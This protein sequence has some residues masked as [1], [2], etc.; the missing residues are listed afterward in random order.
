V[1]NVLPEPI[2]VLTTRGIVVT[3]N[4]HAA[5]LLGRSPKEGAGFDLTDFVQEGREKLT[6]YL[7]LCSRTRDMMLGVLS[8]KLPALA[9][10]S[11]RCEGVLLQPAQNEVPAL[12]MLRA[13]P[14][15]HAS[16]R[17]IV[18][19][20]KLDALGKEVLR[21]TKAEEIALNSE[22]RLRFAQQAANLGSWEWNLD[23]NELWWSD[24]ICSLHGYAIGEIHPTYEA[25]I[26]FA[27][28]EDREKVTRGLL[29]AAQQGTKYD[30]DY[31]SQCP[32]GSLRWIAVRGQVFRSADRRRARMTGI[33]IDI[34]RQKLAEESLRKTEKL[35]TAGRLAATIAHEINNPLASVTNLLYLLRSNASLD[36]TGQEYLAVAEQ[37]LGRV[38]H[39]SNQTLGFYR[40]TTAPV[41]LDLGKTLRDLVSLY[42]GKLSGK[43]IKVDVRC[44]PKAEIIAL[45]GEIRQVFSNLIVNAI[46]AMNPGGTLQVQ[47][48]R[49]REWKNGGIV[50]A[51]F[52]IADTGCG[53]SS[54]QRKRLFEPFYTTKQ[55]VGTGLGL[56]VTKQL[57]EKH[58]GSIKLRSNA[59]PPRT[60]TV[61]SVF[62][63]QVKGE[64]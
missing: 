47:I 7:R 2:F 53:I 57:I 23:T 31:R 46:D 49:S 62:L 61:F 51:R 22:E 17:F 41:S 5:R 29:S 42:R 15:E 48:R 39:I 50:G 19:N 26:N 30:V 8:F 37:E 18:L 9:P 34:T 55:D 11:Y 40:D 1:I 36:A 12:L 6:A 25:W 63:P 13:M 21:R 56:W 52:T 43:N 60:G 38:T 64:K 54:E 32:D 3:M 14:K 4:G 10:V 59:R 45:S 58:G 33:A 24:T 16:G 28:P 20:E 35:A 27:I 44:H